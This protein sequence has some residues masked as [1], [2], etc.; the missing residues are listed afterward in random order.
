MPAPL[1]TTTAVPLPGG[2]TWLRRATPEPER[3][4]R[5]RR[6]LELVAQRPGDR[7]RLAHERIRLLAAYDAGWDVQD[8]QGHVLPPPRRLSL[9]GWN[10]VPRA[11]IEAMLDHLDAQAAEGLAAFRV[12]RERRASDAGQA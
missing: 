11:V 2:H 9:R 1:V 7:R 3:F 8:A 10:A 6:A 12:A 4:A 5:W